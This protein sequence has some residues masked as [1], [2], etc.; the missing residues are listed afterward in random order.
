MLSYLL[1]SC[2]AAVVW[3]VFVL[4]PNADR[5]H[6]STRQSKFAEVSQSELMMLI[7]MASPVLICFTVMPWLVWPEVDGAPP[8]DRGTAVG[9]AITATLLSWWSNFKLIGLCINRCVRYVMLPQS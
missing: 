8:I 4:K 2:S 3:V 1:A 9:P 5:E 7:L 6:E